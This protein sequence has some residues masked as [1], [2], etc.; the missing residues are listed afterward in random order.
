MSICQTFQRISQPHKLGLIYWLLRWNRVAKPVLLK[1]IKPI[2]ENIFILPK[3]G[4]DKIS[5]KT[6][7][8]RTQ[9][10]QMFTTFQSFNWDIKI[11]VKIELHYGILGICVT[12]VVNFKFECLH[13]STACIFDKQ[14]CLIIFGRNWQ[15]TPRWTQMQN[16]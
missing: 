15:K 9:C 2:F 8:P 5:V 3:G 7:I 4:L 16:T 13:S 1:T 11:S 10:L 6:L 14:S 12:N